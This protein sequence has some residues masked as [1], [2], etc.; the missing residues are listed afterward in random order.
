MGPNFD[1]RCAADLATVIEGRALSNDGASWLTRV[2]TGAIRPNRDKPFWDLAHF[3]AVLAAI[4]VDARSVIDLVLNPRLARTEA[5]Q[6]ALQERNR[7]S[8]VWLDDKGV[9]LPGDEQPWRVTWAGAARL[10][11]LAEFV[12]TADDLAHF[13]KI[14][15][16]L[17]ELDGTS[18]ASVALLT[19]RFARL[20]AAYRQD[21]LP[22]ASLESRFRSILAFLARRT[23]PHKNGAFDDDDILGYWR[24]EIA[25]G[26]RPQFRTVAEHFVTYGKLIDTLGGLSGLTQ[27]ASLESIEGWADRLEGA[28]GDLVGFD[29][30]SVILA[31]ALAAM[32]DTPK[33]LTGAERDDLID[34]VWLDPF[35]RTLPLTV[36]RSISFGRVQSGIANRLRRGGGGAGIEERVGC[37]EAAAYD[38]VMARARE[39]KAHVERMLKIAAALRLAGR[40]AADERVA[41]ILAAAEADIKR[42]RRSGFDGDRATLA[43]S[44]AEVDDILVRASEEMMSFIRAADSAAKSAP[45]AATFLA[46]RELFAAAFHTAYIGK[47]TAHDAARPAAG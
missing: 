27:A 21:H 37:G 17:D 44:F 18:R 33:I 19:R 16:W 39:L 31:N 23:A 30:A 5:L 47:V 43:A 1:E 28:L 42:V 6:R 8:L 36:L 26:D 24:V 14:G 29:E 15:G 46:D 32:P 25:G 4:S 2:V 3:L 35:H 13:E 22:L 11:A 9:I 20:A 7:A 45:L 12:L 38:A 10:L 40:P 41:A 34:I